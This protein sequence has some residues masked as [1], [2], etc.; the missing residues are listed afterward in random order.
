MKNKT[1]KTECRKVK[2]MEENH[3][4]DLNSE[5]LLSDE[6]VAHLINFSV[7][8]VRKERWK[9]RSGRPYVLTVDPVMIGNKPRYRSSEITQWINQL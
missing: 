5:N 2:I 9:K 1:C 3:T 4:T 7:A 6:Q 8:W